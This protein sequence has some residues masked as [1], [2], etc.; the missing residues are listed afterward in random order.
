METATEPG[1]VHQ[2]ALSRSGTVV[3]GILLTT[4]APES[5]TPDM[6]VDVLHA[7]LT[8]LC[9]EV[10]SGLPGGGDHRVVDGRPGGR[11]RQRASPR[12]AAICC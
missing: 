1:R 7:A 3:T 5:M 2:F 12:P 8:R 6:T 10:P 9:G 11:A 4:T